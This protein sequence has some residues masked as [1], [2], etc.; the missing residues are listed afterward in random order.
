MSAR[1]PAVLSRILPGAASFL[2]SPHLAAASTGATGSH[3]QLFSY[4]PL[5]VATPIVAFVFY[6]YAQKPSSPAFSTSLWEREVKLPCF[7]RPNNDYI[8]SELKR[9]TQAAQ[10]EAEDSDAPYDPIK[11]AHEAR[12][13]F[14]LAQRK[15]VPE[16]F[17]NLGDKEKHLLGY[18]VRGRVLVHGKPPLFFATPL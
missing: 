16:A 17:R 5:L 14:Q 8:S 10:E 6:R 11:N 4:W 18:L 15:K 2:L 13:A 12:E 3:S 9:I 1:L 7:A